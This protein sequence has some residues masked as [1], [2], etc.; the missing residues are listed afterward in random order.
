MDLVLIALSAAALINVIIALEKNRS[1]LAWAVLGIGFS[2]FSTLILA[3]LSRIRP[4]VRCPQCA[5]DVFFE[6]KVCQH[7]GHSL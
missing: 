1:V 4:T 2:F 6:A 5:N 7:C 3:F